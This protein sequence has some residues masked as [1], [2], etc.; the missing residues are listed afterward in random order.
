MLDLARVKGPSQLPGAT[1]GPDEACRF[2][3][4][5]ARKATEK[6]K[7][8]HNLAAVSLLVG[9]VRSAAVDVLRS[10]GMDQASALEQALEE[11]AGRASKISLEEGL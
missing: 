4:E 2:A 1:R 5:A 8:R 11:V 10:T 9:Q 3:L 7:E 6:F